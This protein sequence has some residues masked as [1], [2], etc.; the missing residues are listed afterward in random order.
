MLNNSIYMKFKNSQNSYL[1]VHS[2]VNNN[3]HKWK[4]PK[5]L[6]I[7][8]WTHK[9]NVEYSYNGDIIWLESWMKYWEV[10]T[11]AVIYVSPGN[12]ILY[13]SQTQMPIFVCFPLNEMSRIGSQRDRKWLSGCLE[14]EWE[15]GG[16]GLSAMGCFE[17]I[18]WKYSKTHNFLNIIKAIKL[19]F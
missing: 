14:L 10:S 11:E 13:E 8:W 16:K 18:Q 1:E 12:I 6:S 19:H 2:S 17:E 5:F 4:Q 15:A 7:N 3:S 9:Q